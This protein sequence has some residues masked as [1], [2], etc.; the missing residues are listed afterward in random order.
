MDLSTVH[1]SV[2]QWLIGGPLREEPVGHHIMSRYVQF[3]T[4][5][6]IYFIAVWIDNALC[7][8]GKQ[9][10]WWIGYILVSCSEAEVVNLVSYQHDKATGPQTTEL[11]FFQMYMYVTPSIFNLCKQIFL[12]FKRVNVLCETALYLA[13]LWSDRAG[14]ALTETLATWVGRVWWEQHLCCSSI[15]WPGKP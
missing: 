7:K 13:A 10:C 15:L 9:F 6:W 1:L 11:Y 3:V 2:C 12:K 8:N 14:G 5:R 4:S